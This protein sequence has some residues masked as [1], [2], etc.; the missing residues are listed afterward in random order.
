MDDPTRNVVLS[1]SA[2]ITMHAIGAVIAIA[3]RWPAQ[4]GGPGDPDAVFTEL[5]WRGGPFTA[6]LPLLVFYSMAVAGAMRSGRPGKWS[7]GVVAAITCIFTG[8][9]AGEVLSPYTGQVPR[10]PLWAGSVAGFAAC[11]VTLAMCL[12]RLREPP[13]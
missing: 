2:L 3:M 11:L 8:G 4:F 12:R 7:T 1:A 13:R 10:V 9:T 5:F 6:P